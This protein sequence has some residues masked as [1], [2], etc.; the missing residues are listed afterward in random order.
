MSL[1]TGE[2]QLKASGGW[3]VGLA[4]EISKH[5]EIELSIATTFHKVKSLKVSKGENITYYTFPLC[6]GNL[7]YNK[8][9]EKYWKEIL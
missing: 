4:N 9:H 5:P 3:M 1:I 6:K 8:K 2:N 7:W